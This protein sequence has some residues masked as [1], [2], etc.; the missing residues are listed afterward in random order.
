MTSVTS[1]TFDLDDKTHYKFKEFCHK[2]HITMK[3]ALNIAVSMIVN[4]GIL[5]DHKKIKR[6]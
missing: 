4:K 5:N 2:K 6:R 3:D 1:V